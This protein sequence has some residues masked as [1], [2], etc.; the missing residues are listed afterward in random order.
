[1]RRTYLAKC[2]TARIRST[3]WMST[4][5]FGSGRSTAP[6]RKSLRA[7]AERRLGDLPRV[8]A[9]YWERDWRREHRGNRRYPENELWEAVN[10][11]LD[12]LDHPFEGGSGS[13]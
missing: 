2:W 11:Y 1:M 6:T 3:A 5:R 13:R 4:G 9:D 7:L 8:T 12:L 10:G